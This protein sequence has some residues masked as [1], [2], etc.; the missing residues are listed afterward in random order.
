VINKKIKNIIYTAVF[1]AL[2]FVSIRFLGIFAGGGY[3]HIGDMF[4][5]LAGVC[6]PFPYAP[7]AGAIGGCFANLTNPA[8]AHFAFFT[9][10]IKFCVAA[11][12]TNKTARILCP[13]NFIAIIAASVI[14]VAGYGAA[15]VIFYGWAGLANSYGDLVQVAVNAVIFIAAG[16]A[17]DKT[18]L[19][20]RLFYEL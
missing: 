16:A 15:Y 3:Y 7:L 14:T 17:F 20:R 18:N 11:C 4:I 8:V 12:F 9:L 19:R 2:I 6:L 13:R 10:I 5:Y 1:S